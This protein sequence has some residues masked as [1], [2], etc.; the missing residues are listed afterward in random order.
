MREEEK[1]ILTAKMLDAPSALTDDEIDAIIQDDELR[2]IY[3][4]SSDLIRACAEIAPVDVADEWKRFSRKLP[5][6]RPSMFKRAVQVAAVFVAILM[7][8][9][10]AINLNWTCRVPEARNV[11][12]GV[13]KRPEISAPEGYM[14]AVYEL[15]SEPDAET[16]KQET[17]TVR[18][19]KS[20]ASDDVPAIEDE[21]PEIEDPEMEEYL[22]VQQAVADNELASMTARTIQEEYAAFLENSC[23]TD[24]DT[25]LLTSIVLSVT[26]P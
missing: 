24:I 15:K 20:A 10:L 8:A 23:D 2:G 5:N 21:D 11:H 6:R 26:M 13:T 16:G 9:G 17:A 12:T 25:D 18:Q 22:R 3:E 1:D 14:A 7:A 4:M 19:R